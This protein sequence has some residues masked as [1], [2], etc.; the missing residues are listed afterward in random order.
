M[1]I[2]VKELTPI[3]VRHLNT[4]GRYPVGGVP[5]LYLQVRPPQGKSWILRT[6]IGEKTRDMG[7]GSFSEVSLSDARVKARELRALIAMGID[8]VQQAKDIK[9]E[10][11]TAQRNQKS[12]QDI[13]YECYDVKRQGFKNAKH[14]S[15]WIGSVKRYAFDIIGDMDI[16]RIGVNDVLLV[17]KPI[18]NTKTE[19]ASRLRQRLESIF[20]HAIACEVRI[21]ANPARW[22]GCLK[23]LLASPE[24]IKKKQGKNHNHHAA[25]P[26]SALSEFFIDLTQYKYSSAQALAICILTGARS[27]EVRGMT[28][29]EL[30]MANRVWRIDAQRMKAGKTHTVPL[31][32]PAVLMLN[33]IERESKYPHVF[34]NTKGNPLSDAIM[35][36]VIRT[37]NSKRL[38]DGL[39]EYLDPT[40]QR[41]ITPHGF[42]S[43]LKDWSRTRTQYSDEASE[44]ALAHV[45]SDKTRVAY[46]RDELIGERTALMNDWGTFCLCGDD[47]VSPIRL[48]K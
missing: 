36:K 35:G 32:A 43:T 42:R 23:P 11:I 9:Q 30:D 47:A 18:W 29:D 8:P 27:G 6:V 20:D 5:C 12:F 21:A 17:L 48:V 15:Q 38:E 39:N 25:L 19:T 26:V 44:L 31:N 2:R 34:R 13:A 41:I 37:L 3:E 7:L 16:N 4:Y 46:A 28:W 40:S 1:A 24:S 22:K 10:Q 14:A 33:S 45:S